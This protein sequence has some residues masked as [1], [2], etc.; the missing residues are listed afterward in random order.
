MAAFADDISI[1]ISVGERHLSFNA[2]FSELY[3]S[4]YNWQ[5]VSIGSDNGLSPNKLQTIYPIM[6]QL[7]DATHICLNESNL[8]VNQ[9]LYRQVQIW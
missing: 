1:C 7:T 2:T 9:H 5:Q 6:T 3:S 4:G 8:W